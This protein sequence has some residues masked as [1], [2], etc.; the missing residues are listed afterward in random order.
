MY[1]TCCT[2]HVYVPLFLSCSLSLPP[3]SSLCLNP[4]GRFFPSLQALMTNPRLI[5]DEYDA[6]GSALNPPHAQ[7]PPNDLRPVPREAWGEP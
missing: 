7:R 5:R 6:F 1:E 2:V 3:P 4:I